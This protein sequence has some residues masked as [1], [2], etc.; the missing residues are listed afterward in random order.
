MM[1]ADIELSLLI[2]L[3]IF[4]CDTPIRRKMWYF[5]F[6][7]AVKLL[8]Q[9]TKGGGGSRAATATRQSFVKSI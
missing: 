9:T 6:A 4:P 2:T 7:V 1:R 3:T 5:Y 8:Q